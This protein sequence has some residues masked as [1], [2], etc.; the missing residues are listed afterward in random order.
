MVNILDAI[1]GVTYPEKS[2][3]VPTD[4][5]SL[6]RIGDLELEIAALKNGEDSTELTK[7][8]ASL[9]LAVKETSWEFTLRGLPSSVVDS[10]MRAKRAKIKDAAAQNKEF[11]RELIITS[12]VRVKNYADEEAE[13]DK[14][15]L[16]KFLDAI[17]EDVYRRFSDTTDQL[18]GDALHYE[19]TVTDPNFS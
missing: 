19:Y 17:P 4:F 5:K 2:I 8:Q 3:L 18:S 11:V 12:I 1:Q 9:I 6:G 15:S 13:F 14:E 10:I 7:E 16:G